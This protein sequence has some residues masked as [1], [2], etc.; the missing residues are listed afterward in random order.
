MIRFSDKQREVWRRT[1]N[2]RH[3]WNFSLG[4]T[5]SGKTYL[6]YYKL[7]WRIRHAPREG[8]VVLLGNTQG[9]LSRNILDP[10]REIWTE[11]LV[12]RIG[13][14]NRVRL[15]GRNCYAL[16]ADKVTQVSKLQGAGF[17]YCYGDEVTTWHEDVFQMLKSRLDKPGSCFD[18]TCNPEG[19]NH[20][21]KRFLDSDADIYKMYFELDDNP[22][23]AP[24]FVAAL[25]QEYAGTVYYDR[26]ILGRWALADGRI[27]DRFSRTENVVDGKVKRDYVAYYVSMDYGTQNAT[28]MILWGLCGGVWYA[29]KEYYYSGRDSKRQKDDQQYYDDLLSFVGD[30]HI[31]GVVIDPSAASMETCIRR[32]GKF[33]TLP[34]DNSVI[35]GIRNT[36]TALNSGKI[37]LCDCCEMTIKQLEGYAWDSKAAQRG[38]DAPLK[39]DDHGPDA[40]RYFVQTVLNRGRVRVPEYIF[41]R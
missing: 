34:A 7:P 33:T 41:G 24:E 12:G 16:G 15:F 25:K 29:V 27:Y 14:D 32:R 38:I 5:R 37:K 30:R 26:F 17:A 6:D 36:A 31:R 40:V 1:V 2:E 23:L 8:H 20:W 11:A 4:A 22:F 13:S 35:D 21:V 19:P 10:L 3:R 18:G 28:V 39:E 9:T